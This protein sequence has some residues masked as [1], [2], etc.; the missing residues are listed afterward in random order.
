MDPVAVADPSPSRRSVKR[1]PPARSP[2]LSPKAAGGG[3][4][5]AEELI[6]RVA[7]L[8]AAAARLMG[9][10]E[11]AEEAA[12]ALQ[13]ELD[14]ERASAETATSEAMLMIERLQ[15]EKASAQMEARQFRRYAES[16]AD[17]EREVQE[18]LATLND[19]AASYHSRLWSHGI[20]PDSFSD[21]DEEPDLE[22]GEEAEQIAAERNAGDASTGTEVKAMVVDDN[23]KEDEP[24]SPV[25]KEFEYTVD[26]SCSSTTKAVAAVVTEYVGEG[27][28]GG[29]Y[30][31]VEALEADRMA[32]R[33]E[34]AALRAERA[35]LVMARE[36]ARRLC[37][38]M[39]AEQRAIVKK[40]AAPA[41]RFSALGIC[42][43]V[44]SVLFWRNRSST[45]KY[46]YLWSV[47]Y[48]PWPPA[49]SPQIHNVQPLATLAK[50]TK[51][52]RPPSID[53]CL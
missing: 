31:R 28:S 7:E 2:E 11:A 20:D 32:M 50:A 25:E 41:G 14:A 1:R 39:V 23:H 51:M 49:A 22:D 19:L 52:I 13:E 26:V 47:D 8:E 6:R 48:F 37:W 3:D 35:Q 17:H 12:R 18:E 27:N 10:K 29:L 46:V 38:E 34:L 40:T 45:A 53:K 43:W 30:A 21:E 24:L 36:M 33:R 15:R 5:A 16:R 44:L 42:K 4:D 9:E